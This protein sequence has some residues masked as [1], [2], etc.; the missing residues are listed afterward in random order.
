M[1]TPDFTT[2]TQTTRHR[3]LNPNTNYSVPNHPGTNHTIP[4]LHFD[5]T[6]HNHRTMDSSMEN[7]VP[8][9]R[10]PTVKH[11]QNIRQPDQNVDE[12]T[13]ISRTTRQVAP[14]LTSNICQSCFDNNLHA[15]CKVSKTWPNN[16]CDNCIAAAVLCNPSNWGFGNVPARMG[17]AETPTRF[18]PGPA[19]RRG[20]GG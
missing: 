10:A 2:K 13:A 3:K 18:A 16:Q 5:T 4:T 20:G 17:G 8:K 19:P 9:V 6:S 11:H 12:R 1:P 14:E 15:P 7:M